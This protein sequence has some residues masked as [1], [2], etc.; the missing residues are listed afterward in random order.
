MIDA[1]TALATAEQALALAVEAAAAAAA[2]HRLESGTVATDAD[3]IA[4]LEPV[5]VEH[6]KRLKAVRAAI[7]DGEATIVAAPF[8][9]FD[10]RGQ[11]KG[12]YLP[13]LHPLV[14]Q[15]AALASSSASPG[16]CGVR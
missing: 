10:P 6:S 3:L 12:R 5:C 9:A 16:A 11:S 15:L 14:P 13:K 4:A 2:N 1:R 7:V 8:G